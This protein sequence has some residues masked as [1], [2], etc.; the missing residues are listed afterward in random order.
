M[1]RLGLVDL[2]VWFDLRGFGLWCV[3]WFDDV[4]LLAIRIGGFGGGG[5]GCLL[6]RLVRGWCLLVVCIWGW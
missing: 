2:L 3:M 4:G 5:C 1:L 6:V